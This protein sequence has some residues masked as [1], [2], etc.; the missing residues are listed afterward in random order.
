MD[1]KQEARPTAM[2]M[3]VIDLAAVRAGDDGALTRALF[4]LSARWFTQA[5][6][7]IAF[8]ITACTLATGGDTS[9]NGLLA[10][11]VDLRELLCA[12]PK[13]REALRDLGFERLL[14][15]LEGER[16]A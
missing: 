13:G 3:P 14:Q 15:Y 7:N 12:A 9:R 4:A 10:A 5:G 16:S 2:R 11:A 6:A 1:Q 8:P